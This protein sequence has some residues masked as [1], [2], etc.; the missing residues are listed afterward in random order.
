[1]VIYGFARDAQFSLVA[2]EPVV[3]SQRKANALQ[4]RVGE[5]SSRTQNAGSVVGSGFPL[6]RGEVLLFGI[7]VAEPEAATSRHGLSV[8]FGVH[9]SRRRAASP[10][11]LVQMIAAL[12]LAVAHCC[13][14]AYAGP[15]ATATTLTQLLQRRNDDES[16]DVVREITLH[17]SAVYSLLLGGRNRIAA[18]FR[19]L[20]PTGR[21]LNN[22]EPAH[23]YAVIL[24]AARRPW[25]VRRGRICFC[26]P[27]EPQM[28]DQ[29]LP[30][31]AV[32]TYRFLDRGIIVGHPSSK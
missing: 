20:R 2:G 3:L 1:M 27:L 19:P 5:V 9:V 15:V 11:L 28:L 13:S 6:G 30:L 14:G 4:L 29:R 23:H 18:F 17:L 16:L 10:E 7:P 25:Y 12:E 31:D 8:V 24:Q 21:T 32:K 26:V 22:S